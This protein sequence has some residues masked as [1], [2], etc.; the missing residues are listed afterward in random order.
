[1]MM[2]ARRLD[3]DIGGVLTKFLEEPPVLVTGQ[4]ACKKGGVMAMES[5]KRC[6]QAVAQRCH[7]HSRNHPGRSRQ[8]IIPY[9]VAGVPEPRFCMFTQMRNMAEGIIYHFRFRSC[10][11]ER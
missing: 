11:Q 1:I 9:P 8:E 7:I 6:L 2:I 5:G 10:C 3:I 4:E